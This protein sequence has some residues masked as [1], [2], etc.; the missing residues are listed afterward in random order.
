MQYAWL[1][2]SI[3]ILIVWAIIYIT[4]KK[5]RKEMLRVSLWT[6]LFGLTEPLFV[7]EYWNPPTLFDLAEKT[8]FDIESL[9]FTF[10]IGGIGS[11]L[12]KLVNRIDIEPF[13]S[14]ERS[15]I[16]H[17]VHFYILLTPV[18]V[19]VLLA[20]LTKLNHI[21]CGIIAMF[22]GAVA[23][24]FCR[25]DLNKKIWVG[26]FLF[27]VLYFI[28]FEIL[29]LLHPGYVEMVWNL[30]AISGILILGVPLEELIWG[31]TFGMYWSSVYEHLLWYKLKHK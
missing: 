2:W 14:D 30:N 3:I 4:N 20:L 26:G 21:Y 31:F 12:Y 24:L 10:S 17:R 23:T 1:T 5:F 27:F 19:F 16:R 8:G 6:M 25:P 29:N 18:F 9:I 7:P 22:F 11:V 15:N 28:F 13:Q